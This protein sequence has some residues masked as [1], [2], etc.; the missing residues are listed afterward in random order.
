MSANNTP[1]LGLP[2][3][4]ASQ[5]QK[6]VTHN[7]ALNLIDL[8]VQPVIK[9]RTNI[10]PASPAESDAYIVTTTATGAWIGKENQI[11]WF[12]GGAWRFIAPFE[13]CGFGR[14]LTQEIIFIM[15]M[16]GWLNSV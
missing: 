8:L 3:I 12:I 5:A 14:L 15:G 6:E 9:G 16:P 2:Y 13:A 7:D 10:P 11:A 4:I 1:R